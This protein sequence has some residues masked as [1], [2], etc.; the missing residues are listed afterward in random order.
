MKPIKE[1]KTNPR[2]FNHNENN[3]RNKRNKIHKK[4]KSDKNN[5]S[6]LENFE[7]CR[8]KMETE[9]ELKKQF[10]LENLKTCIDKFRQTNKLRDEVKG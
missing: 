7:A 8:S 10:Y 9:N 5:L 1:C 3:L 6:A 2:S 4:W